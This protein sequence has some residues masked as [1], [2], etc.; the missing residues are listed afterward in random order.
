M[1][2][3]TRFTSRGL[4]TFVAAVGFSAP[5]WAITPF[6]PSVDASED[7][8]HDLDAFTPATNDPISEPG[9]AASLT[10]GAQAADPGGPPDFLPGE[11]W[12]DL[13][14]GGSGFIEE[15]PS[16]FQGV[17]APTGSYLGHVPTP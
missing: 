16:G 7:M 5:V 6:D 17:A 14:N 4:L 9:A 12:F 15:V 1:N 8:E 11:D 10:P 13:R 2:R 3:F